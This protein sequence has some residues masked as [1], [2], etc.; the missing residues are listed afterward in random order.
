MI[1]RL[2]EADDH[3]LAL[4]GL[5]FDDHSS[6]L[7]GAAEAPPVIR[8]ALFSDASNRWTEDGRD[9]GSEGVLF[10]AGDLEKGP[11]ERTQEEI[12]AVVSLL[13]ARG[14]RP[15]TTVSRPATRR[16]GRWFHGSGKMPT[17]ASRTK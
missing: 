1:E 14:L 10:D 9:L 15:R 8:G 6:F 7:R 16:S 2:K 4:V 17:S 11:T 3:R 5:P 13:A 12:D